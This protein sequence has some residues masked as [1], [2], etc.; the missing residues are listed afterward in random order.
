MK[1]WRLCRPAIKLWGTW[2]GKRSLWG[3]PQTWSTKAHLS[4]LQICKPTQHLPW[5]RHTTHFSVHFFDVWKGVISFWHSCLPWY[6][7]LVFLL[8]LGHGCLSG[9]TS[10]GPYLLSWASCHL[11]QMPRMASLPGWPIWRHQ[12][13]MHFRFTSNPS[14]CPKS[15]HMSPIPH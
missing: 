5:G 14:F 12:S 6:W 9:G 4:S 13:W 10:V 8:T 3:R 2:L 1:R 7:R 11:S 15:C